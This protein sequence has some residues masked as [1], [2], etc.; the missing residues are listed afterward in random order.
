MLSGQLFRLH[1]ETLGIET[2]DDEDPIA[3]KVPAGEII[4]VISGPRPDDLRMVD[5]QWR[6]TKLVMF[7]EDIQK[8]GEH[9]KGEPA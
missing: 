5:V 9:V 3:V 4:A 8:R 6:D 2:I 1:V 7:F